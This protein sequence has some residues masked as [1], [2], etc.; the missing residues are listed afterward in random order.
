MV[1]EV[2]LIRAVPFAMPVARP[3]LETVAM[4]GCVEDQVT[5]EVTSMV[6]PS[7]KVAVALNCWV[8][9]FGIVVSP[10]ETVMDTK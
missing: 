9:P 2:A 1:P 7:E 3:L 10:G 5:D 4:V 8:R 6:P